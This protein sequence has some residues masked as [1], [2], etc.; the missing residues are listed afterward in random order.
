MNLPQTLLV[1]FF[2]G[3]LPVGMWAQ[4]IPT[5]EAIQTFRIGGINAPEYAAFVREPTI[6]AGSDNSIYVRS[7]QP[8]AMAV[9]DAQGQFL[10][11]IGGEGEGPGE[12]RAAIAHGLLGDTLWVVDLGLL[13]AS[14]FLSD[15]TH[16]RTWRLEPIDLGIRL[17]APHTISAFLEGPYALAIPMALP[18]GFGR[19]QLPVLLGDRTLENPDTVLKVIKP[20]GLY[21]EGVGS[22][23]FAPFPMPPLVS[24]A[25]NG[26]GFLSADWEAGGDALTITRYQ[27]S[28]RV[29]WTKR[30]DVETAPIPKEVR[31]SLVS[32]GVS[33]AEPYLQRAQRRGTLGRGPLREVVAEGLYLPSEFPPASQIRL[34]EDGSV[35]IRSG[36]FAE[37]A[38]WTVLDADG[39]TNFRVQLPDGFR[40]QDCT[41]RTVWGTTTDE[42]DVPYIVR[43]D[44]R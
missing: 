28:G 35:W 37:M 12:F 41:L 13:R 31:D 9:F 29:D 14:T 21:V 32:E 26:S 34:G 2:S 3:F 30:L 17:S 7:P 40:L 24:V 10:R 20:S 18:L 36:E 4:A 43:Y 42:I 27:P 33:I 1:L 25:G 38:E 44:I 11:T 8:P 15:G 22:F 23:S 16:L 5:M 19:T 6:V 39:Q